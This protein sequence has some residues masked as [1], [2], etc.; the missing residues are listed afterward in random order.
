VLEDALRKA[1]Q[2]ISTLQV[3]REDLRSQQL[4][5]I[6][7]QQLREQ[8]RKRQ[9]DEW[10]AE[11]ERYRKDMADYAAAAKMYKDFYDRN[12]YALESL[13]RLQAHVAQRQAE[14]QEMQRLAEERQKKQ[15]QDWREENE[16]RWKR[17]AL[18]TEH[19]WSDQ[20]R[21][22]EAAAKRLDNLEAQAALI[23][24]DLSRL[25]DEV[26]KSVTAQLGVLHQRQKDLDE[27][28]VNR[29]KQKPAQSAPPEA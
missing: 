18:E 17:E 10:A 5:F 14:L 25:W 13:E 2:Q 3:T 9:L 20:Q 26:S 11:L 15:L 23:H 29:K 8:Q 28:A 21:R 12:R 4:E 16:K 1:E 22:N 19:A 6:E 27:I 7:A 24:T